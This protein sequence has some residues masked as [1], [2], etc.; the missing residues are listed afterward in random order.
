MGL[1][2]LLPIAILL[3]P[4]SAQAASITIETEVYEWSD[5]DTGQL[6]KYESVDASDNNIST[7][8]SNQQIISSSTLNRVITISTKNEI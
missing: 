6:Q 5:S 8:A 4:A 3:A 1:A 7:F 2:A